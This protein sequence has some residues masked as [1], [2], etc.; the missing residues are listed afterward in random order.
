VP[1]PT[2]TP[3]PAP[4]DGTDR[5]AALVGAW[6]FDEASGT[7]AKD[8]SGRGNG[9]TVSGA[10]RVAGRY[11][12]AL[13]FDGVNDLVTVAD[14]ASLDLTTAMTIEAWVQP[15]KLT[16][17]WRTVAVKEQPSQL[18]YALYAGNGN[19]NGNRPSGHVNTGGDVALPG[20]A[21]LGTGRWTHLASTWDGTTIRLYVDGKEVSSARVTG[22]ATTSGKPLR[23]GG[24]QVW[25]EWFSGLI[26]EVRVYNR[27]LTAAEVASDRDTPIAAASTASIAHKAGKH[28]V[29]RKKAARHAK[30]GKHHRR[31]H[32]RRWL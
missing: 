17:S 30:K 11:G 18:S 21:S 4:G 25:S 8:L 13:S 14:S 20:T 10:K 12:K 27:A 24:N 23:I 2:P 28:R 19:N 1:T 32:V 7:A 26:D 5:S 15:S 9:G 29:A 22:T 6:A 31:H 16:G 3:A